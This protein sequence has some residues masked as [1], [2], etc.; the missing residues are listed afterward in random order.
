MPSPSKLLLSLSAANFLSLSTL[1]ICLRRVRKH[2]LHC[3]LCSI[4][5]CRP[6]HCMLSVKHQLS[7]SWRRLHQLGGV[8]QYR[9]LGQIGGVP[10]SFC[11]ARVPC[12]I[13]SNPCKPLQ[14]SHF[15]LVFN[16]GLSVFLLNY[17]YYITTEADNK[18]FR[19]VLSNEQHLLHPL[20]PPSCDDHF[21][22]RK[23]AN[24][25]LQLLLTIP[26]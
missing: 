12:R 3:K 17:Y 4:T 11:K 21:S 25:N 1:T 26:R 18:L 9:W 8:W 14:A 19:N 23:R 2:W 16:S 13:R 15:I 20:L 10:L 7:P 6:M 24:H 22:L 5:A